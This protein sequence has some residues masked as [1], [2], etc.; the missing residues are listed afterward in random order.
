M[1][2]TI[3]LLIILL[4]FAFTAVGIETDPCLMNPPPNAHF[5]PECTEACAKMFPL[6]S[7]ERCECML[8]CLRPID[9]PGL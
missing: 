5:D 9:D 7:E 8:S 3:M 2:R 6:P 1:K 4:T